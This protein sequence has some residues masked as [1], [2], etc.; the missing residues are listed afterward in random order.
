MTYAQFRTYFEMFYF[1]VLRVPCDLVE[2]K[3]TEYES[4]SCDWIAY[5][6]LERGNACFEI[7]R[8]VESG[9]WAYSKELVLTAAPRD[10]IDS[11]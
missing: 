7:G 4:L 3:S 1:G 8:L 2:P 9:S 6:C 10:E 5:F 11:R